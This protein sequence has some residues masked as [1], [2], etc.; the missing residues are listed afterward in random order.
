MLKVLEFVHR[1]AGGLIGLVLALLGLSGALLVFKDDW[2][3]LPHADDP[4]ITDPA[5]IG[6]ATARLLADPEGGESLVYAHD[7]LGLIQLRTGEA[8][9]AYAEQTGAIITRWASFAERPELWLFDLHHHLLAGEI[10]E[11]MAGAA[12]LAALLFVVTGAILWWRTRRTFRLRALPRRLTRPA[13][14]RHHRDLGIVVGPLLFL[15]ALTGTMMVFRPVADFLL[16]PLGGAGTIE[17]AL[18]PPKVEAG[19][20]AADLDWAGIVSAAHARFPDA[21]IRI[22]SLPKKPGD[23]IS[24]RMKRSAEW[25]PNGRSSVWF[26]P[27]TGRVLGSRDAMTMA[28]AAQAFNMAYPIHSAKVGGLVWRIIASIIGLSLALLGGLAVWSFWFLPARAK[29]SAENVPDMPI[30]IARAE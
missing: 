21:Q 14:V 8:A 6:A 10:G 13:I 16:S 11:T 29:S 15:T 30:E 22:L 27:A 23:P 1:W 9:G 20:L 25:L 7:R 18:K 26:D 2:I 19:P 4:L 28:P 17:A 3:G 5:A 12:G 24:V